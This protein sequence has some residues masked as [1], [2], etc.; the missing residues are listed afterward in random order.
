[1][2]IALPYKSFCSYPYP[3]KAHREPELLLKL[4]CQVQ[5]FFLSSLCYFLMRTFN[6]S[7]E[8]MRRIKRMVTDNKSDNF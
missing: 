4:E 2:T 3:L 7:L 1:M 8:E 5:I 6:G